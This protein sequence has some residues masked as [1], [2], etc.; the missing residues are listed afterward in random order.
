M[1]S[2]EFVK[3]NVHKVRTFFVLLTFVLKWTYNMVNLLALKILLYFFCAGTT[4]YYTRPKLRRFSIGKNCV[5][6]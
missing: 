5:K 3:L 4:T 6:Y 1:L 2:T